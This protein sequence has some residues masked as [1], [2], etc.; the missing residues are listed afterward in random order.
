MTYVERCL[1]EYME[2]VAMQEEMKL[3]LQMLMSVRGQSYE[4]HKVKV[5]SNPVFEVASR[6]LMIERKLKKLEKKTRP[7]KKLEEDL[8]GSDLYIKQM[9]EILQLRYMQHDSHEDVMRHMAV[10]KATYWRRNR[11]LL[12]KARKY[13]CEE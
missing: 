4:A 9:L 1:Y 5:E 11:E 12:R 3:E 8:C 6:I 13:L 2:N 10:S 7:V